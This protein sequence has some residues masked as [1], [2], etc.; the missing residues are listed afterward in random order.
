M[1][2]AFSRR[3]VLLMSLMIVLLLAACQAQETSLE[4]GQAEPE[5]D[6]LEASGFLEAEQVSVVSEVNGRIMMLDVDEADRVEAGDLVIELDPLLLEAER[7]EALAAVAI[8]EASLNRLLAGPQ[9]EDVALAESNLAEAEA[10]LEGAQRVAGQAWNAVANPG[11]VEAQI[12]ATETEIEVTEQQIEIILKDIQSAEYFLNWLKFEDGDPDE[13]KIEFKEYELEVLYANL[14]AAEARKEGAERKLAVLVEQRDR[15]VS[16]IAQ[17]TSAQAQISVVEAQIALAQAQLDLVLA[18]PTPEEIALAET[19]VALAEAQVALYDARLAQ[20]NLFAPIDGVITTRA[21]EPGETVSPGVSLLTISQLDELKIVVYI[22]QP[23]IS[24]VQ[25]G[26]SVIID[27][28]GLEGE[29]FEGVVTFIA[30]EAEFTPRNVVT[31]EERVD[32]V[33]AVEITIPNADGQLQPG[34]PADVIIEE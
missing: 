10:V 16:A 15:P 3:S 31:E 6:L 9:Q 24:R 28:D 7:A 13:T 23:K 20:L 26:A 4:I 19:Q 5:D 34:M 11:S 29:S 21:I 2:S 8:A 12:A 1:L 22:P 25:L 14:R 27:V 30:N 33:F 17:A 32:Q 18:G